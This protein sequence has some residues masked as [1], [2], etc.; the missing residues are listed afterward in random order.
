MVH[1][2]SP[3]FTRARVCFQLSYFLL[4]Q[5]YFM[6]KQSFCS[7]RSHF[8]YEIVQFYYLFFYYYFL[9]AL[10]FYDSYFFFFSMY[11]VMKSNL[12]CELVSKIG[13]FNSKFNTAAKQKRL[14]YD[15]CVLHQEITTYAKGTIGKTIS[16]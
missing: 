13:D 4:V 7:I 11:I 12:F 3:Q 15:L 6:I 8:G 5:S 2:V 1:D 9:S 16:F 14:L 10:H